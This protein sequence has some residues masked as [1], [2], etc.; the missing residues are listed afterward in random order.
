[1]SVGEA[2]RGVVGVESEHSAARRGTEDLSRFPWE[3]VRGCP[4][5]GKVRHWFQDLGSNSICKNRY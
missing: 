3:R 2:L 1:V 5:L 4:S